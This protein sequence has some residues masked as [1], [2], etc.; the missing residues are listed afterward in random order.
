M[1]GTSPDDRK[2]TQREERLERALRANLSR[3]K[4]Q[5]RARRDAGTPAGETAEPGEPGASMP[6]AG[7]GEGGGE[8]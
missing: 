6:E 2:K 4:S 3:R 1:A 7:E 5:A 8:T